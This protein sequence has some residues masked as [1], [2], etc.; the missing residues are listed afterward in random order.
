MKTI[1]AAAAL[2]YLGPDYTYETLLQYSGDI[3]PATGF[4][5]GYIYIVGEEANNCFFILLG[6]LLMNILGSGDPSLGSWR[7]NETTTADFI[8]KKWIDAI[9]KAG[10]KKCRGVIG[11]TSRWN[12]TE[13]MIIDGWTWNDIGYILIWML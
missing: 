11:D 8:V 9:T 13:T 7:Y 10:I 6:N 2:Y 3:D 1:T 5:D 4:L 12:N